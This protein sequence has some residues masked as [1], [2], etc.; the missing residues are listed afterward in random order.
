[1][2]AAR[3]PSNEQETAI[4]A[5]DTISCLHKGKLHQGVLVTAVRASQRFLTGLLPGDTRSTE[6][7]LWDVVPQLTK[8]M[9]TARIA[10]MA[11]EEAA[12]LASGAHDPSMS[13][14][15]SAADQV[16]EVAVGLP[17]ASH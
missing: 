14:A 16:Q 8:E 2:L 7:D 17:G 1:M 5:G 4:R 6:L 13:L 3:W 10:A 12:V 9:T 15:E 11:A